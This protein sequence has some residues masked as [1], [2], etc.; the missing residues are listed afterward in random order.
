MQAAL[1]FGDGVY[2]SRSKLNVVF[3]GEIIVA[4]FFFSRF[5]FFIV[6]CSCIVPNDSVL[7]IAS[8]EYSRVGWSR[9][10]QGASDF[11]ES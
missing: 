10:E 3:C 5:I 2:P 7:L 1:A 8:V 4:G 11:D 6:Q 9:E